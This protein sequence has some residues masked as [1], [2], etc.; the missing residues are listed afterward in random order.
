M[1][2]RN[3]SIYILN[4]S[5][6]FNIIFSQEFVRNLSMST[7]LGNIVGHPGAPLVN[8]LNALKYA[9][10]RACQ[11]NGVNPDRQHRFTI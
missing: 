6:I 4:S 2:K 11:T 5:T 1:A 10:A 7:K 8:V 9:E 3:L